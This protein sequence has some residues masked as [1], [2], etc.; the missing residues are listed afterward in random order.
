MGNLRFLQACLRWMPPHDSNILLCLIQTTWNLQAPKSCRYVISRKKLCSSTSIFLVPRCT[1]AHPHNIV[2]IMDGWSSA[3]KLC[4][5]LSVQ[6]AWMT[7]PDGDQSAKNLR[8]I[9]IIYFCWLQTQ[10]CVDYHLSSAQ[11]CADD[12][13]H[14]YC[15]HDHP[16]NLAPENRPPNSLPKTL[17][18]QFTIVHHRLPGKIVINIANILVGGGI[19]RASLLILHWGVLVYWVQP[20]FLLTL[21]HSWWFYW[22]NGIIIYWDGK[23]KY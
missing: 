22:V 1:N 5:W 18:L 17:R 13:P 16:C 15:V 9:C 12:Y 6:S 21:D 7:V 20:P 14:Q 10:L 23:S 8:W 19:V 11:S 4:G 3:Q 2:G